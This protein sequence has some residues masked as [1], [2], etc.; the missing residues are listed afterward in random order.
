MVLSKDWLN[1]VI[2]SYQLTPSLSGFSVWLILLIWLPLIVCRYLVKRMQKEKENLL[3]KMIN[4][5]LPTFH[6]LEELCLHYQ[7]KHDDK[8]VAPNFYI[9]AILKKRHIALMK[10]GK[11]LNAILL[12]DQKKEGSSLLRIKKRIT[13]TNLI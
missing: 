3:E 9:Q 11:P 12:L 8:E 6:K 2:N 10:E 5:P 7:N 1:S 13:Y 4:L